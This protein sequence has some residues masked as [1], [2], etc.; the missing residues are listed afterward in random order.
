MREQN[1]APQVS[2]GQTVS[3]WHVATI[4]VGVAITLPAFLIGA[5]IMGAL[6]TQHGV[7]AILMGGVILSIVA[8]V[9][10][11]IAV[12]KRMTTY[13]LLDASFGTLGS[14]LVSFL[15]S[16]TLLGW[17]GVTASL[18]GQAMAK[19][20]EELFAFYLPVGVYVVIGCAAMIV[21]T[22]FGFRA[23][24][25][26]SKFTVPLM[27]LVLIIGVYS[28]ASNFTAQQ[29]W[30][31]PPRLDGQTIHF[32]TAVSM[33]VGSFM[34]GITI[35][36]DIARFINRKRE[37]YVASLSSYGSIF[38]FILI[39]AGLPGL[40][41]GEKDLIV[42]MY[43]SSLGVP[44]LI[45]IIFASLTTNISNLYSCS[46]GFRQ[47]MPKAKGW[48]IMVWS[49]ILGGIFSLSGI[50]DY[51]IEFLI[52]LSILI[53]P[54][55][56]IYIAHFFLSCA[57]CK[58]KFSLLAILSWALA[59]GVAFA[60]SSGLFVLTNIS[61]LDSL[62]VA[63]LAYSSIIKAHACLLRSRPSGGY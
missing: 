48:H 54:I 10:M 18:F 43:Q 45:M 46:L 42:G 23:I 6:G 30:A 31:A 58:N 39:M 20:V 8:S 34:V 53:P 60:T 38:A 2:K 11:Y 5:E 33:V 1:I 3:G 55:A 59:S 9:C 37:V 24:N 35:L 19:S 49:G 57:I 62:L 21:I 44:A 22:I 61:A 7:A 41:T 25:M 63:V 27:L 14:R 40:M 13:Q 36:P 32:G 50:M 29:I 4:I 26:L 47:V 51:V 12:S 52:A 56:G 28:I 17:F 16:F 15:V